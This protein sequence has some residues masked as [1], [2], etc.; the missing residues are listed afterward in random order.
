MQTFNRFFFRSLYKLP[1]FNF[2]TGPARL[3]HITYKSTNP[4]AKLNLVIL[5]G[6]FGAA[7]NFRSI[8]NNTKISQYANCYLLD[9]RNHGAS[10]HR[11]TMTSAEMAE[12]VYYWIKQH[13]VDSKDLVIMGHSMGARVTMA[14]ATIY[15]D[16]PKGVIIVDFA[17]YNYTNDP[18]FHTIKSNKEMIEKLAALKLEGEWNDIKKAISEVEIGRAHV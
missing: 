4:D 11:D 1:C 6:L 3:N 18:R 16:V 9:L 10:E 2:G 8:V 5:H 12:D 13:K 17:P 15:P 14:F 7:Q